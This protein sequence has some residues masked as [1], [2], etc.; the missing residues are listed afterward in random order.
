MLFSPLSFPAGSAVDHEHEASRPPFAI[1]IY[2]APYGRTEEVVVV[3]QIRLHLHRRAVEE[4]RRAAP[5]GEDAVRGGLRSAEQRRAENDPRQQ[6]SELFHDGFLR[7]VPDSFVGNHI[8][9]KDAPKVEK[10]KHV[11]TEKP[12]RFRKPPPP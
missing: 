10:K 4:E 11:K 12:P 9:A 6:I 3:D 8:I 1:R 5:L 2:S 7:F